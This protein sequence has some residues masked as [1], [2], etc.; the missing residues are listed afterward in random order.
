MERCVGQTGSIPRLGFRSLCLQDSPVGVRDTDFNTVFPAGV[1]V[2]ATWD[3]GL[4]YARGQAMGAEHRDK[5]VDM[6]LGPVAGP[7]GRTPEGGRNWEGFSPDPY[8]TGELFAQSIE[9]I[10]SSGVMACAKH[11]IGYEQDHFRLVAEAQGYGFTNVTE[12]VTSN[13]DD[14]TMHELYLWPFANAVRSGVAAVMCS[15]NQINGSYA[16]QNSKALGLLKGELGFQ[17]LVVSDWD[18]SDI[19]TSYL[20]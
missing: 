18:V 17:G 10:Q 9:G 6:Q 14:K 2:A 4:A 20:I 5:G 7:L 3:R 11:F 19:P 8:L 12:S 15:Y 1:N 13:I 16:C